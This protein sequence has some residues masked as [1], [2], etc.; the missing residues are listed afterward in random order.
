MLTRLDHRVGRA[1]QHDRVSRLDPGFTARVRYEI[2]P[3]AEREEGD[4]PAAPQVERSERA[5]GRLGT[6]YCRSVRAKISTALSNY[7][8]T[9]LLAPSSDKGDT[10]DT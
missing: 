4:T 3:A 8:G 9:A 5:A 1:E 6:R 10:S 7:S 2:A